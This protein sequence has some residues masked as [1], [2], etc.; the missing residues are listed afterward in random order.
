[1]YCNRLRIPVMAGRRSD[2]SRAIIP[3][4]AGRGDTVYGLSDSRPISSSNFSECS[5]GL[6]GRGELLAHRVAFEGKTIGVMHQAIEDGIGDGAV[7]EISVPLLDRQLAGDERGTPVVA[8]VEDLEQIAHGLIGERRDTEVVDENQIGFSELAVEGRTLLQEAVA[9][10]FVNESGQGEAA[11]AELG[12]AGRVRQ[13]A[14]DVAFADAGRTIHI[15][16]GVTPT[17]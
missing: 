2:S 4:H 1:M 17:A 6:D 7:A 16:P 8:V 11:Y 9:S 13:C 3:I 15:M 12:A 5:V 10:Q 14:G